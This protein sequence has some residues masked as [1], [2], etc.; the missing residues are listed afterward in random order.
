MPASPLVLTAS[1]P[2]PLVRLGPGAFSA[3]T[4][5]HELA[6][7]VYHLMR[8]GEAYVKRTEEQ[9]GEEVR[10]RQ[11]RQLERRAK[12]MGFGLKR[13]EPAAQSVPQGERPERASRPPPDSRPR[14]QPAGRINT[15]P[16]RRPASGVRA[17]PGRASSRR[18][19]SSWGGD[20][21]GFRPDQYPGRRLW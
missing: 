6:R 15:R 10:R 2:R 18:R 7:V 16:H 20:Q 11:E 21:S 19:G 4:A 12:E 5:A 9:D 1:A 17:E 3:L 14:G 13:A 8:F